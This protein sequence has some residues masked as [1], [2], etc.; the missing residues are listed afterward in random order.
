MVWYGMVDRPV[1]IKEFFLLCRKGWRIL[2]SLIKWLKLKLLITW[3]YGPRKWTSEWLLLM[4][5]QGSVI[6]VKWGSGG[7]VVM[8][9]GYRL[10]GYEFKSQQQS[11]NVVLLSKL[12]SFSCRLLLINVSANEVYTYLNKQMNNLYETKWQNQGDT[13][14]QWLALVPI[15]R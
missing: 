12:H 13:V 4:A 1:P 5:E 6:S 11:D 3:K 9:L 7:S 10:E 8:V 14:V 15:Q 2:W